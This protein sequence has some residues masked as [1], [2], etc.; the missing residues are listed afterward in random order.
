VLIDWFTVFAQIINFLILVLL[1]RRFLYRPIMNAMAER[2]RKIAGALEQ[3]EQERAAAAAEIETYQQ[4]NAAFEQERET[5][6]R[7]AEAQVA[8]RRNKWLEQARGEVDKTRTHWQKALAEEKE[9]FLQTVRRQA[10]QQTYQ[11]IR[12]AL[13][14]LADAELEARIVQVFLHRLAALPKDDIAA[15]REAI[16]AD[17]AVLKLNSGFEMDN[18][19]RQA[20]RQAILAHFGS[21]QPIQMQ[22]TP[23]LICGLELVAPGHK[24]AWS[25]A[26]YLDE[27]EEALMSALAG[28]DT[29]EIDAL[30]EEHNGL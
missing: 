13:A 11:V 28:I 27:L 15:F 18:N 12:R 16:Q 24:L 2:E 23:N 8:E 22:T 25:L 26:S 1:L 20:L 6:I 3:A 7:E 19:Q 5:L 14:D 9:S 4:K 17:R 30:E 29:V 10:G 21:G